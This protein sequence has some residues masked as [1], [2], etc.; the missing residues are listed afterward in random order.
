MALSKTTRTEPTQT[1]TLQQDYV[2]AL[3]GLVKDYE[4]AV[5]GALELL[6]PD[7]IDPV[8]FD[9]TV[10]AIGIATIIIPS[11]PIIDEHIKKSFLTGRRFADMHLK[12]HGVELSVPMLEFR[13]LANGIG[14][15][16]G[17]GGSSGAGGFIGEGP[18]DWR[19]IDALKLANLS[20]LRGMNEE[21]N[22][23][24]I[25]GLIEGVDAG[26]GIPKLTKRVQAATGFGKTRATVIA[27]TETLK[28]YNQSAE[29]RYAQAGV[30][31]LEWLTALD[32]RSMTPGDPCPALNGKIFRVD[33]RHDRPPIHPNCR[34]TVLPVF[35]KND[36]QNI[37]AVETSIE[38]DKREIKSV[39]GKLNRKDVSNR[40]VRDSLRHDMTQNFQSTI[41]KVTGKPMPSRAIADPIHDAYVEATLLGKRYLTPAEIEPIS[42]YAKRVGI[43]KGI[44]DELALGARLNK[45]NSTVDYDTAFL[46]TKGA[47]KQQSLD[48]T[49]NKLEKRIL[50]RGTEEYYILDNVGKIRRYKYSEIAEEQILKSSYRMDGG[51]MVFNAIDA[52]ADMPLSYVVGAARAGMTEVRMSIAR[53]GF[54]PVFRPEREVSRVVRIRLHGVDAVDIDRMYGTVEAELIN[55]GFDVDHEFNAKVWKRVADRLGFEYDEIAI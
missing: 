48:S 45:L 39:V 2:N 49:I 38:H 12:R 10:R 30:E 44:A 1:K 37:K 28:A 23:K 42:K 54:N 3:T 7:N 21:I 17:T 27:R 5:V 51:T 8:Q 16:G 32:E 35:E 41:E 33:S 43:E 4:R 11:S 25:T 47:A 18:A 40:K 53:T 13:Q 24:V 29:L 31:K 52:R 26:E 15:F 6:Q 34:C 46:V 36:A 14:V 55:R 22:K 50:G 9:D 20:Y 19:T